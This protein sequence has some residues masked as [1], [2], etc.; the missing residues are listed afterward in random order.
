MYDRILVPTDG[1]RGTTETL[2]HAAHIAADNDA[3]LHVLYVVDRRVYLAA[4]DDAKADIAASME[5]EGERA[6]EAATDELA[7]VDVPVVTERR[8][9]VP[10]REII[11]YAEEAE[12]D[13]V[14]M[15]THGRTGR[16]RLASMGSVTER[17]VEG[18]ELPV[19]VVDIEDGED[20]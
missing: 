16:D 20:D 18:I 8:E 14:T 11:E 10:H 9:G 3:T 4:D 6:L 5:Q 2:D 15:G 1:S 19:L 12:I 17:V 7:D 13:L